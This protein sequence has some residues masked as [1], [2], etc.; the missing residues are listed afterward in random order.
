MSPNTDNNII[1]NEDELE[2][3]YGSDSD[4]SGYE[5]TN[6]Y[7]DRIYKQDGKWY[8]CYWCENHTCNKC[9]KLFSTKLEIDDSEDLAI[10]EEEYIEE[11]NRICDDC[12]DGS[13]IKKEKDNNRS[14][15]K[16][17]MENLNNIGFIIN[18]K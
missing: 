13:V 15:K 2:I 18:E 10:V 9:K 3:D 12:N 14:I 8:N 1:K 6:C 16:K 11:K 4:N 5:C 17:I 7:S